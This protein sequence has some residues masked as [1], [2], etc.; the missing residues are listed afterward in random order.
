MNVNSTLLEVFEKNIKKDKDTDTTVKSK[1]DHEIRIYPIQE[2]SFIPDISHQ[3]DLDYEID[4]FH[5][6]LLT[7]DRVVLVGDDVKTFPIIA[8]KN[9]F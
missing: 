6:V 8:K 7:R 4:Y 5:L 9:A 1:V 2:D 3:T